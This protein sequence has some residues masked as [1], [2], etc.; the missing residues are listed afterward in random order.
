VS[1]SPFRVR[2]AWPGAGRRRAV[3]PLR[4]LLLA[5][6]LTP[7][8]A[9]QQSQAEKDAT[10]DR[11]LKELAAERAA[12]E[13]LEARVA[14]LEGTHPAPVDDLEE[15]LKGLVAP[16]DLSS[17]PARP[18][19]SPAF[20]NP[21]IGVFMDAVGEG[22]N[23]DQRLGEDSDKFSLRE[24][25]I[26]MRLPL[27]PFAEGVGI[28]A[29][30]N[31][32][33]GEF[34]ATIEEGYANL[35]LGT[36]FD[37]NVDTTAKLG[38]FR[39]IFGRNNALHAHDWLQVE[40]PVAVR[41]LIGDEGV[42][43]E[44]VMLHQ[45]LAAWQG[46][47]GRGRTL[48][49]DLSLVNGE[50]LTSDDSALDEAAGAAGLS[51]ESDDPMYVA[52]LSQFSELGGLS[53]IELG[54]SAM[55]PLGSDAQLTDTGERV[56][57]SYLDADLTWRSRTDEHGVGSWL[58]QAEALRAQVDDH[59]AGMVADG[60]DSGWWLTAQHQISPSVYIGLLYGMSD[61]LENEAEDTSLSPYLTW[62]ADEFFRIRAEYEHLTRDG[63]GSTEDVSDANRF[64]LQF[65][66]NF[67]VHAPHPYWVNR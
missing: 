37:W 22:G 65:T 46:A 44:G 52:R 62:Y 14:A 10:I 36:L 2:A 15:Q 67:G 8:V 48:N 57:S 49:V 13:A 34:D 20:Y 23:F 39:P 47:E 11:L 43:G 7:L 3:P 26:D 9:A 4:A 27:S 63:H 61:V 60:S 12:R 31:Q 6:L 42:I 24:A 18:P 35:D 58:L 51:L 25:E 53:D 45:P 29:F 59:D 17:A 40:Q 38:R 21:A 64:Q 16:G 30:E 32:G 33:N 66:W 50:L 19:S 56:K 55:G 28:F 5:I 1:D 54:V 41:N